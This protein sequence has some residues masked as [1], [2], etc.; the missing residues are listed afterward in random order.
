MMKETHSDQ[1]LR[2]SERQAL[3]LQYGEVKQR[4]KRRRKIAAGVSIGLH[5]IGIIVLGV[6]FIRKAVLENNKDAMQS[7]LVTAEKPQAKRRTLQRKMREARKPKAFKI[8]APKGQPVTTSAKIPMGNARF[9]LPTSDVSTRPT[10][11]PTT[12][13]LGRNLFTESRQAHIVTTMP[14][15]EV[16]KFETTSLVTQMDMGTNLAQMEFNDPGNLELAAVDFGGAEQSVNE[17]LKRVRERI[18]QV[19][20]FPPRVRNLEDGTSTTV[21]FTLFNDGTVRHTEVTASSG[22]LALDNAAIAAVQNAVPYP[23]FPNGHNGSSLRLELPI[24]F[25]LMN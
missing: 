22:S 9:T 16:P 10:M 5:A 2:D 7:V 18:Q 6:Y 24:V 3:T 13:G 14:K 12:E 15:F 1:G 8:R 19:Q 25:E 21:R 11:A 20:R 4:G 17:F 23:P